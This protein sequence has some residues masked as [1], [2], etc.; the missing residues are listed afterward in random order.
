MHYIMSSVYDY[1]FYE[2]TRIGED[3]CECKRLGKYFIVHG[4]IEEA[5]TRGCSD[6]H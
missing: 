1:T 4:R 3:T 2:P 5:E 6:A